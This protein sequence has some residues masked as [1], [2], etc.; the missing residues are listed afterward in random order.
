MNPRH[1]GMLKTVYKA[2][3]DKLQSLGSLSLRF[4]DESRVSVYSIFFLSHKCDNV[5]K[6]SCVVRQKGTVKDYSP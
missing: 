5:D 4:Q 6:K 2:S 1:C 3:F